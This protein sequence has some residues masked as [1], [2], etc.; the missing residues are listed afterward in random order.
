MERC[1]KFSIKVPREL[2]EK[3]IIIYDIDNTIF[4]ISKRYKISIE[5]SGIDP[6]RPLKRN[7]VRARKAFWKIFLSDKYLYLDEPDEETIEDIRK[8]YNEGYGIILLTGRPEYMREST[9]LQL[10]KFG[11]PYHLLIM[12]PNWN[13]DP[14]YLYKPC[15]IDRLVE[16]GLEIK[17]YHEDDMDTVNEIKFRYPQINV[18]YHN[19]FKKKMLF[20]N[21]DK[22]I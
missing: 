18:I 22:R 5:E 17:E 19:I 20:H 7:P 1:K 9:K 2:Y 11:I 6:T 16:M 15:I 10:E 14:D 8:K 3:E 4:D 13:R 12:R 21:K